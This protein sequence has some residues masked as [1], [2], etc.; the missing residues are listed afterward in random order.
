MILTLGRQGQEDVLY[1]SVPD[2]GVLC[3]I[4]LTTK[5]PSLGIQRLSQPCPPNPLS[6][7]VNPIRILIRCWQCFCGM[8]NSSGHQDK[9]GPICGL[10]AVDLVSIQARLCLDKGVKGSNGK[11]AFSLFIPYLVTSELPPFILHKHSLRGCVYVQVCLQMTS[12]SRD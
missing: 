8:G 5:C 10:S 6:C 9:G 1:A 12:G 4:I 3:Q 11:Q 7:P 2:P